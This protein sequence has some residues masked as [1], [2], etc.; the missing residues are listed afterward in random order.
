M[1]S[2]IMAASGHRTKGRQRVGVTVLESLEDPPNDR[3][4]VILSTELISPSSSITSLA[5]G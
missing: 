2:G 4:R 5:G 3:G 1:L